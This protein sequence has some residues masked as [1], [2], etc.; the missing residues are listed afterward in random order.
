[1]VSHRW[2]T[3]DMRAA[4][5]AQD[6]RA[7]APTAMFM[8]YSFCESVASKSDSYQNVVNGIKI[9]TYTNVMIYIEYQISSIGN[10]VSHADKDTLASHDALF[11]TSNGSNNIAP[12]AIVNPLMTIIFGNHAWFLSSGC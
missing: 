5:F 9:A 3:A 12:E 10:V 8:L 7:R 1:M 11:A 4:T 6:M 2:P